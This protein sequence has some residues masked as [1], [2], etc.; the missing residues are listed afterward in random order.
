MNQ[1]I[2]AIKKKQNTACYYDLISNRASIAQAYMSEK[3]LI[4]SYYETFD[5]PILHDLAKILKEKASYNPKYFI[6]A[7]ESLAILLGFNDKDKKNENINQIVY[8]PEIEDTLLPYK[9]AFESLLRDGKILS[10]EE[11]TISNDPLCIN[12]LCL[13]LKSFEYYIFGNSKHSK[14]YVPPGGKIENPFKK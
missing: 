4:I 11:V 14:M 2:V 3:E 7:N 10:L 13:I 9:R 1:L 5:E 12:V 6:N 8:N